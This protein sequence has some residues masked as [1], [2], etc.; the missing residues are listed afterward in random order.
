MVLAVNWS[1]RFQDGIAAIFAFIPELIGALLILVIGYFVAK[2]IASA[3]AGL[4]HR[5]D[6][7][8]QGH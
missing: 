8:L 5:A 6:D 3:V 4:L 7:V 1:E 2:L